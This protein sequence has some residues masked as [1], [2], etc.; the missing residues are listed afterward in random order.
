MY[1]PKWL[2]IGG[3]TRPDRKIHIIGT[4]GEIQGSFDKSEFIV[5][6]ADPTIES[7][8]TET[9]YNLNIIG[10]KTGE[11]GGHGGGDQKLMLDFLDYVNGN[12][13]S[14][15]CATLEDSVISHKTVFKAEKA[16]KTAT[17]VK[18]D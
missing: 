9:V 7:G 5:R 18:I 10:D 6:K 4:K 2:L 17:I 8:Y 1:V 16:R 14:V 11:K 15:S 3:C 13:P 12:A